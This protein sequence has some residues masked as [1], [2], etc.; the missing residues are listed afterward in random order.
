MRAGALLAAVE[1]AERDIMKTMQAQ[2]MEPGAIKAILDEMV[3]AELQRIIIGLDAPGP[4]TEAVV[5]A[6]IHALEAQ[7]A[8]LHRA[9]RLR[10]FGPVEERILQAAE[11]LA[12]AL[13][14]PLPGPLGRQAVAR[15]RDLAE[16]ECAVENGTD[17]AT[18]A[19]PLIDEHLSGDLARALGA[20]LTLGRAIACAQQHAT[21]RDMRNKYTATG[22]IA[23]ELLGD[24]A[25]GAITRAD[26]ERLMRLIIRLPKYHGKA[27]GRNRYRSEGETLSKAEEIRRAD[28]ADRHHVE[29]MAARSDISELEKRARLRDLLVPRQTAANVQHHLNR[30]RGIFKAAAR[31]LDYSGEC[32]FLTDRDL[33]RIIRDG[34]PHDRLE[35][36]HALPKT[37]ACWSHERMQKL[38]L[39]PVYTGCLSR[40]RRTRPGGVIIRDALY[41]VPLIVMSIGSRVDEV[42]RLTKGGVVL[43]DDTVCL[44]LNVAF[45][46]DG[47]TEGA[48]RYIPMPEILL[49]LGF[50]EWATA[51]PGG[52]DAPLFPE[53]AAGAGL[54]DMRDIFGKRMATVFRGIGIKD[55][56]EDF[57]ALRRTLSTALSK[58]GAEESKRQAIAGHSS[59]TVLNIHYTSHAMQDLKAVLDQVDFGLSI[60][61][62]EKHGF[63]V[64]RG[65]DLTEPMVDVGIVLAG[66][67]GA[68]S[69]SIGD[70]KHPE[71]VVTVAGKARPRKSAGPLAPVRD[72]A[73]AARLVQTALRGRKP[74]PLRDPARQRALEHLLM[75]A[76]PACAAPEPVIHR[77]PR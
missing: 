44:A 61:W 19:A 39:S 14:A 13:E 45:T 54:S 24:V 36:H 34:K 7:I 47:K 72:A 28:A 2:A 30:F 8:T 32:T 60:T 17:I 63:P 23:L 70:G 10:D 40:H 11:R 58:A 20:P 9:A 53:I 6:R 12:I 66:D 62:S 21:S 43:R 18:A 49:R 59:G 52:P 46:E 51:L 42:L 16:A 69:I 48:V 41:W 71:L 67:G 56:N 50:A 25:L 73:E 26:V 3:R 57:Y 37:R 33:G 65:C 1:R 31:H 64:I 68:A 77:A 76:H 29:A 15:A 27:H 74:R 38:L 75:L 4:R 55:W 22:R 35:F 5:E